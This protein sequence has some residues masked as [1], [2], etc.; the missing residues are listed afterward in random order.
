M[1]NLTLLW[2]TLIPMEVGKDVVLLPYYLGK[3]LNFQTNI[4]CE[5]TDGV[6]TFLIQ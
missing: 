4:V 2:G 1:N 6:E 3:I 5:F